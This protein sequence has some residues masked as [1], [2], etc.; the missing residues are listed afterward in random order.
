MIEQ[1]KKSYSKLVED[2]TYFFIEILI[3]FIVTIF[4]LIP[5]FLVEFFIDNN[6]IFFAPLFFSTKAL[7]ILFGIPVSLLIV[8]KL[9]KFSTESPR[10]Q[11]KVNLWIGHLK[12][13][14]ISKSNVKFQLLFGLL[15]LF[16]IFIPVDFITSLLIPEVLDYQAVMLTSD[17]KGNYFLEDFQIFIISAI[18]IHISVAIIEESIARGLI[19]K[20]GAENLPI[21]S[22]VLISSIYFGLGHFTYLLNPLSS[23]YPIWFPF[24]WFVETFGIGVIL[25]LFIIKKKW[26]FPVIFAHALNNIISAFSIWYCLQGFEFFYL[27]IFMY[28]PL[29]V[30]SIILL[31]INFKRIK[32]S[33][34]TGFSML[35]NISK[36]ERKP[37]SL[38]VLITI[39]LD[40]VFAC[41]IFLVG[42]LII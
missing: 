13:F 2:R 9:G 31:V 34:K 24:I 40:F 29:L 32:E 28:V 5:S 27:T 37:K 20:R 17:P 1:E 11:S 39:M 41:L 12:L 36:D 15:L 19:A 8:Q 22:A 7:G 26:I 25:A 18:I 16:L 6:S 30:I 23:N 4:F 14:K 35:G 3:V 21:I 38:D 42:I 10:F 33:I